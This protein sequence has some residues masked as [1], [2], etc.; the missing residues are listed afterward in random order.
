MMYKVSNSKGSIED[1]ILRQVHKVS[2]PFMVY[3]YINIVHMS[4]NMV[5]CGGL[6]AISTNVSRISVA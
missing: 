2:W 5:A 1:L 4:I 6:F 3:L